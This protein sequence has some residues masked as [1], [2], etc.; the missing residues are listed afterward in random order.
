MPWEAG[1]T[2]LSPAAGG[3]TQSHCW[4]LGVRHAAWRLHMFTRQVEA[5]VKAPAAM[6]SWSTGQTH[7]RHTTMGDER[8]GARTHHILDTVVKWHFTHPRGW[9]RPPSL[10][11]TTAHVWHLLPACISVTH[12]C[13]M[14]PH[15]GFQ[16]QHRDPVGRR[17][18]VQAQ[19]HCP[20]AEAFV[21]PSLSCTDQALCTTLTPTPCFK[22]RCAAWSVRL[23]SAAAST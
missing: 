4:L 18:G 3:T 2:L 9:W 1:R 22:V 23:P 21:L 15:T 19:A 8:K 10:L 17:T 16:A 13:R 6:T 12:G 20:P 11:S 7:D 14:L 5:A